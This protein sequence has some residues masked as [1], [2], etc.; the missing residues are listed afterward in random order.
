MLLPF[1]KLVQASQ[2]MDLTQSQEPSM[3]D[4]EDQMQVPV[5]EIEAIDHGLQGEVIVLYTRMLVFFG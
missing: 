2:S 3:E 4:H 5:V 1:L